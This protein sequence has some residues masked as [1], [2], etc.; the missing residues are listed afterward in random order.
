MNAYNCR[1]KY[2]EIAEIG[3]KYV[4]GFMC[5]HRCKNEIQNVIILNSGSKKSIDYVDER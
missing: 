1:I 3:N 2:Y 4:I 5:C